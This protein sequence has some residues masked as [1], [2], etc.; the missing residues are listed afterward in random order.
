MKTF[1]EKIKKPLI[2]VVIGAVIVGFY[3]YINNRKVD[4]TE[5]LTKST[6][7]TE[8]TERDLDL[9]YPGTVRSV[10]TFYC[11]V[12]KVIYSESLNNDDVRKIASKLHGIFDDEFIALHPFDKYV[13]DLAKEI[14]EYKKVNRIVADYIVEENSYIEYFTNKKKEYAK[15][16]VTFFQHVGKNVYKT[17]EWFLLRKDSDGKWKIVCW[18]EETAKDVE[19]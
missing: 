3:F 13:D 15:V 2:F 16:D 8:I 17:Y 10:L 18:D 12:L 11:D 9:N 14:K 5:K 19:K 6:P 4:N 1:F 7:V